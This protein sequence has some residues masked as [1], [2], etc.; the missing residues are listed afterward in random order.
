MVLRSRKR[1]ACGF[2]RRHLI[3]GH[4][5]TTDKKRDKILFKLGFASYRDYLRSPLWKAIRAAVLEETPKCEIC[6][7]NKAQQVHH[8]RYTFSVLK[9]HP[10]GRK[11]LVSVCRQCHKEIEFK[12]DG[13]KRTYEAAMKKTK[14]KLIKAGLWSNHVNHGPYAKTNEQSINNADG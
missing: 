8:I 10:R 14:Q 12:A 4:A 7:T 9:G 6:G 1:A 13:T 5:T 3:R 2:K 11:S